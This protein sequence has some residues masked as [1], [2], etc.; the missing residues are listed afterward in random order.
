M[1]MKGGWFLTKSEGGRV[2]FQKEFKKKAGY[3]RHKEQ[4]VQR[5][6]GR[7]QYDAFK[8]GAHNGTE[9]GGGRF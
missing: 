9:W 7:S 2:I 5:H 4:G 6:R 1:M 3:S 8:R